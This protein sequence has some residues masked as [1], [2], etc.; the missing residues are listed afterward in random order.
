[1]D[2]SSV[3]CNI[4]TFWISQLWKIAFW[5]KLL[6]FRKFLQIPNTGSLFIGWMRQVCPPCLMTHPENLPCLLQEILHGRLV[7]CPC[8]RW[9]KFWKLISWMLHKPLTHWHVAPRSWPWGKELQLSVEKWITESWIP[10]TLKKNFR[11]G[12]A[13]LKQEVFPWSTQSTLELPT[14][15]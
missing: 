14:E 7:P 1:M 5:I 11:W 8:K 2:L 4:N 3:F 15:T 13:T 10:T 12:W 9:E 6:Q